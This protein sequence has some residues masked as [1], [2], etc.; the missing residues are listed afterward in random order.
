M[1]SRWSINL[2]V[3]ALVLSAVAGFSLFRESSVTPAWAS[4][5][6]SLRNSIAGT[7]CED[8]EYLFIINQLDK[9]SDAPAS[10]QVQLSCGGSITVNLSKLNNKLA[11]YSLPAGDVPGGCTPVGATAVIYDSYSGNFVIS[12][13]PC[14]S[15]SPSPS[16]EPSPSP[17][18]AM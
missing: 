6:I 17:S 18:P 11:L 9:S 2:A 15:P 16:P 4:K 8:D 13:V 12:H 1:R 14:G 3:I 10:I 7:S 5:T